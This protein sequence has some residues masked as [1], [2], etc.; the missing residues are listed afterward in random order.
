MSNSYNNLKNKYDMSCLSFMTFKEYYTNFIKLDIFNKDSEWGW[1]VDTEAN[2]DIKK[3]NVYTYYKS[4]KYVNIPKTIS[5]YPS[6]RS[7]KSMKNL[8]ESSMIFESDD[9][10]NFPQSLIIVNVFTMIIVSCLY[11]Y[12]KQTNIK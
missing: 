12:I 3:S 7:M 9:E 4:S 11:Y 2:Y 6:I 8:H 1:F 5:E 10:A